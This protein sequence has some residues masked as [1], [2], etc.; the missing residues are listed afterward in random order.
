MLEGFCCLL[1]RTWTLINIC[2]CSR[3]GTVQIGPGRRQSL[4]AFDWRWRGDKIGETPCH[5]SGDQNG[6]NSETEVDHFLAFIPRDQPGGD[7]FLN[8]RLRAIADARKPVRGLQLL[9]GRR[10]PWRQLPLR[11]LKLK[12]RSTEKACRLLCPNAS[13]R[14]AHSTNDPLGRHST[15]KCSNP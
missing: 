1:F 15:C 14:C 2:R 3:V 7:V 13:P 5:G 10:G 12:I 6:R 8:Q 9:T 11:R 4:I